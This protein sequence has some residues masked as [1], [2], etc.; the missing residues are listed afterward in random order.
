MTLRTSARAMR[1]PLY[2]AATFRICLL[3]SSEQEFLD[4]SLLRR[5][6]DRITVTPGTLSK[7]SSTRLFVRSPA[8]L[9]S[10]PELQSFLA[11]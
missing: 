8:L 6:V 10:P 4:E 3:M 9:G 1:A 2:P 7:I 5:R 11:S